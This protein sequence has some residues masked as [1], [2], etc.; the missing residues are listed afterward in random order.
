M[1]GEDM[2]KCRINDSVS[3]QFHFFYS[4][5]P[6]LNKL[7]RGILMKSEINNK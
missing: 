3:T 6:L 4:K 5:L 2:P 7:V 1:G